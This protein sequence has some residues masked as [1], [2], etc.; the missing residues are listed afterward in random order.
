[1]IER[2]KKPKENSKEKVH[3]MTLNELINELLELQAFGYGEATVVNGDQANLVSIIGE[4]DN[5]IIDFE[6]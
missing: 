4:N 2:G 6:L 3:K 1:M 5:V